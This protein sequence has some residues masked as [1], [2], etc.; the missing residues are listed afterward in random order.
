[1]TGKGT[2]TKEATEVERV[3]KKGESEREKELL[4]WRSGAK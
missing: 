1:M 3:G 2:A 4:K